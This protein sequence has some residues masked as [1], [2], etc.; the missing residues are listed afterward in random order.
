MNDVKWGQDPWAKTKNA[1]EDAWGDMKNW[2]K[3]MM[4]TTKDAWG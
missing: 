4:D 3:D 2:G 1:T